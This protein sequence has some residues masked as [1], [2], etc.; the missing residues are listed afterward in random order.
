MRR[1]EEMPRLKKAELIQGIVYMGSPVR[2]DRHGIPD[3]RMQGWLWTYVAATPG[4]RAASNSTTFLSQED[5][6]QPDA[7]LWLLPECG[8]QATLRDSGY[9]QGAP[10]LVVE[11]AAS[12]ASIDL[13]EKRSVYLAA[14]VREYLVWRTEQRTLDWWTAEG[15]EFL[16]LPRENGDLICSRVFAGLWLNVTALLSGDDG[17]VLQALQ[18]GLSSAA[19][20]TLVARHCTML[21]QQR[22]H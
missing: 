20:S 11:I 22:G 6:F 13:H 16:P 14:G 3:S 18:E 4:V 2:A 15:S 21:G 5:V 8:G 9:I 1:Y 19:H 10:E 17:R 7:M 12:S